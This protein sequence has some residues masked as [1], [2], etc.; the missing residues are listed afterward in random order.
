MGWCLNFGTVVSEVK[1]NED[2]KVDTNVPNLQKSLAK[3]MN[4]CLQQQS[5]REKKR[6]RKEK[7][8]HVRHLHNML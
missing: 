1:E 7:R 2:L 8:K 6:K 5:R 3:S 4:Y